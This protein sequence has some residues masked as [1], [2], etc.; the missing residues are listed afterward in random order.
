MSHN[1]IFFYMHHT[2]AMLFIILIGITM[3]MWYRKVGRSYAKGLISAVEA[4]LA[5]M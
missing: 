1:M 4:N 2:S 3:N 5:E